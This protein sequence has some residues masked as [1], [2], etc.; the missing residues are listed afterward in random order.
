MIVLTKKKKINEHIK[1]VAFM[2][3]LQRVFPLFLFFKT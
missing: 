3:W 2:G 1:D